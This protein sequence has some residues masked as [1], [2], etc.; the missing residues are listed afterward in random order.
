MN[1]ITKQVNTVN[2]LTGLYRTVYWSKNLAVL[3]TL[4]LINIHAL[5]FEYNFP[6]HITLHRL[7]RLL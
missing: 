3:T 5:E 7:H 6:G 1:A 2:R 4:V